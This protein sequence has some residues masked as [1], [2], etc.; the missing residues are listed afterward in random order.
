[1]N[2]LL[3]DLRTALRQLFRTPGFTLTAVLTLAFGIGATLTIYSIVEGVL[4][5]P[6]PFPEPDRL[7]ILGNAPEGVPLDGAPNVT[8][9]AVGI[10]SRATNVFSAMGAYRQVGFE[11]SGQ[12]EPAQINASRMNAT[13]FQVLGVAP[14]LGRTFTQREDEAGEQVAVISDEMWRDRFSSA[15][16]VLGKKIQLNR[17]TYEIVGVMPRAFEFPLVPGQLNRSELWV[18]MSFTQGE[19]VNGAGSWNYTLLGRLKPGVT[20]EQARQNMEPMGPEI[21]QRLPAVIQSMRVHARVESLMDATVAQAKPLVRMLF[22]AVVV[23]LVIACANLAGLLLV[24]VIRRRHETAVRMAMGASTTKILCESLIESLA[25]SLA[26]GLTGLVLAWAA[27]RV[28]TRF[29]PETLPR[30]SAISL[31]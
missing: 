13:V 9:P 26:G 12:G 28:G 21:M 3:A 25:F 27:L 5:R 24:R 16:N 29:L 31:D 10:Y 15:P 11:L 17:R 1:M 22:L 2:A 8:A 30:I 18:P 14:S 23:V 7:M 19:L 4:M 6:L 20:A